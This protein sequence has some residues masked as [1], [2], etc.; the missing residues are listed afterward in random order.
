MSSRKIVTRSNVIL[1]TSIAAALILLVS[2]LFG[3][4]AGYEATG[5]VFLGASYEL[6]RRS[7]EAKAFKARLVEKLT[8]KRLEDFKE[9]FLRGRRTSILWVN[10][11]SECKFQPS[12]LWR[13]Y[14]DCYSTQ[15]ERE[16]QAVENNLHTA[17]RASDLRELSRL[18]V[19]IYHITNHY[20][21]F[22][23]DFGQEFRDILSTD[24]ARQWFRNVADEY[25][26]FIER[27]EDDLREIQTELGERWGAPAVHKTS[28]LIAN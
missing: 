7:K 17:A 8:K 21:S 25:D 24:P 12:A 6:W 11:A 19:E 15:L 13:K 5:L 10:A 9:K 1:V 2:K 4:D 28:E 27:L 16:L 23:D 20:Y 14:E 18:F 3:I 22:L 26:N